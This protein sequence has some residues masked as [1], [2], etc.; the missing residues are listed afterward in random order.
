MDRDDLLTR[1]RDGRAEFESAAALFEKDEWT[2]PLLPN[3]WSVKDV[4]T[5]VGFW[6]QRMVNLY[7]MLAAGESPR[8]VATAETVDELNARVYHENEMVPPGI[9]ELN[10][11]EAYQALLSLAE[12]A[13]EADLFDPRRFPWTEGEAFYR[14]IEVNTFEHYADHVPDL[15]AARA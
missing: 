3:A 10:E 15:L 11:R 4:I 1:I 12:N 7:H 9:A 8:D 6:E 14:W 13:P 2:K 5:H